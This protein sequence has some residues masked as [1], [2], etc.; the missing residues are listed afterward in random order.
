M[1]ELVFNEKKYRALEP[2]NGWGTVEDARRCFT[3]WI[4][5]AMELVEDVPAEFVYWRW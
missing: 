3:N 4:D 5:E 1:N 2:E